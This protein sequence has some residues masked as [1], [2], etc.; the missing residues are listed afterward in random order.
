LIEART[1]VRDHKGG[2]EAWGCIGSRVDR[3]EA[4]AERRY[5][6]KNDEILTKT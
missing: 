4:G 5:K 6:G 3:E 2:N 1:L